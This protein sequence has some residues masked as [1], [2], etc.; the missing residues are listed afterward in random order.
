[1]FKKYLETMKALKMFWVK[2][3]WKFSE[4]V[5][6]LFGKCFENIDRVLRRC[7]DGVQNIKRKGGR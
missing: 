4:I 5:K 3:L 7:W 6:K 1:M 2:M